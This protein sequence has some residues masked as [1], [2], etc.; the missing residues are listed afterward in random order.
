MRKCASGIARSVL[1][2]RA[3]NG[4]FRFGDDFADDDVASLVVVQFSDAFT[5]KTEGQCLPS[6]LR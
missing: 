5:K 3:M 4:P 1:V 6:F 2:Q